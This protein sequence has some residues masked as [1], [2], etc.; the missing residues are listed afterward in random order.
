M[1]YGRDL[2]APAGMVGGRNYCLDPPICQWSLKAVSTS[3]S[4]ETR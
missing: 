1:L 3:G 2:C 4:V